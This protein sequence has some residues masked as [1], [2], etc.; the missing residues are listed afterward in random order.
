VSLDRIT[1]GELAWLAALMDGAALAA[2]I[3]GAQAADVTFDL[4]TALHRFIGD[5]TI[6]GTI[7][8]P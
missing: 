4:G 6:T 1:P 5:G 7:D 8:L 3:A 2:T